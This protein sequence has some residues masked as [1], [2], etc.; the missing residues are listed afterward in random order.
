MSEPVVIAQQKVA[1]RDPQD[2][3]DQADDLALL[4]AM[5]DAL[6]RRGPDG[7]YKPALARDWTLSE[8]ARRWTFRLKPGL[9]FHD[10]SP[11]DAAAMKFSIERMRR[12]DVGA[13]LGA[14]AV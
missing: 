2:C 3:T 6:V 4:E 8:D 12:P 10:G 5:F 9:K 13:T 11:L 14:P 7:R 1:L